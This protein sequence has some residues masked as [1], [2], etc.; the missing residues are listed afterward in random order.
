[1]LWIVITWILAK[2]EILVKFSL[3]ND[4]KLLYILG[5]ILL[6]FSY[7][8]TQEI[9]NQASY[10]LFSMKYLTHHRHQLWF[11]KYKVAYGYKLCCF[12]FWYLGVLV[13]LYLSCRPQ[14][15]AVLKLILLIFSYVFAGCRSIFK[16]TTYSPVY[17]A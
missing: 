1:M 8:S 4:E 10:N 7:N 3:E 11:S 13:L 12:K 9:L 15:A 5:G 16:L 17:R 6:Q 14:L 2:G